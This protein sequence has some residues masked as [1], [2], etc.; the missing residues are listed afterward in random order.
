MQHDDCINRIQEYY[1][2]WQRHVTASLLIASSEFDSLL[3]Q[4]FKYLPM[5]NEFPADLKDK[6]NIKGLDAINL[7]GRSENLSV[8]D[9]RY[10]FLIAELN[11]AMYYLCDGNY[12]QARTELDNAETIVKGKAISDPFLC[13][14][15][16]FP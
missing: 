9:I 5:Q 8:E 1:E 10:L 7:Y 3:R 11:F 14:L 12:Y 4:Y 13:S 2:Y 16:G 6:F 15:I